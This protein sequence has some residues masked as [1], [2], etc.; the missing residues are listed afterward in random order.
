MLRVVS[1]EMLQLCFCRIRNLLG[2][3]RHAFFTAVRLCYFE[4][5]GASCVVFVLFQL[6]SG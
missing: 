2:W 3:R 4:E 6:A 1:Y 5:R